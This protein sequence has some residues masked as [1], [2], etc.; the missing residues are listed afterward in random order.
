VTHDPA[1]AIMDSAQIVTL[2]GRHLE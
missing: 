1:E 2:S